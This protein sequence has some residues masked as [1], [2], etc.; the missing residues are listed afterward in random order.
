MYSLK[1]GV[2][3]LSTV[4]AFNEATRLVEL[5]LPPIE[6]VTRVEL[7][8]LRCDGTIDGDVTGGVAQKP[9]MCRV[10]GDDEEVM[11]CK[12]IIKNGNNHIDT[13]PNYFTTWQ[14]FHITI[15]SQL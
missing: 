3:M 15:L 8:S 4:M 2:P 12:R 7:P 9:L 10:R 14:K 11:S 5:I 6:Y 13:P 1:S